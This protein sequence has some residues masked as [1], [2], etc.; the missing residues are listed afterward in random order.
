VIITVAS[1]KGGVG[2]TTTAFHLAAFFQ[3]L[4]PTLLLDG[5]ETRNATAWCKRGRGVSFRVASEVQA[6]KLA[7]DFTHIVIDTGQRPRE[8]DLKALSEGCDMLIVPTVP[9]T[10]DTEGLVLT[11]ETLSALGA[12][13]YRVL[14]TKVPPP[15]EQEGAQLR[16]ELARQGI[17]LFAADIPR[18]KA[19]EKAAAQGVPV[20][21]VDDPRAKRGW[22]AYQAV[23]KEILNH[24]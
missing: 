20:G 14:L 23:G 11:I 9:A 12:E 24:G 17:P 7:R 4:A 1:H 2:K 19:F 3:T 10:L 5:D 8:V 6:A 15:P 22:E 21:E 13:R 18:L 16:S